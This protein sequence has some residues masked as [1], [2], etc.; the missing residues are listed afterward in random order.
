MEQTLKERKMKIKMISTVL[1]SSLLFSNVCFAAMTLNADKQVEWHNKEQKVVAIGNAVATKDDMKIS[2]DTITGFYRKTKQNK[3]DIYKVFARKNVKLV[4]ETTKAYGDNL[5]YNLD[6]DEVFLSGKTAKIETQNA[7][8]EAENGIKFYP[9]KNHAIA[10]GKVVAKEKDN[11]IYANNMDAYFQT[12]EN[13]KLEIKNI[14]ISGNLK[15]VSPT[16]TV[17]AVRG[18]Y[19][20]SENKIELFDDVVITQ[21]KN[22]LKGDYAETNLLTGVSKL[23]ANKSGKGR[24]S[25][26]FVEKEKE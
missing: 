18:T 2:A 8:I 3:T 26:V 9:S 23:I 13:G 24:V 4:S 22:I 12:S 15:I 20:P 7:S 16:A 6:K 5:D 19:T 1:V 10:V 17:T 11:T 14:E 21:E 25:G